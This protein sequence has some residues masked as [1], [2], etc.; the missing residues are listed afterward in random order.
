MV[1]SIQ[2]PDAN[3]FELVEE[4]SSHNDGDL[5]PSSLLSMSA[6]DLPKRVIRLRLFAR[7]LLDHETK[8]QHRLT[9]IARD[10]CPLKE[11]Q[12]V[13]E[14]PITLN[15]REVNEY[16]PV[17]QLHSDTT[18]KS[19][20]IHI[21]PAVRLDYLP[22]ERNGAVSDTDHTAS[23]T[24]TVVLEV[25]EDMPVGSR[26]YQIMATDA[27][28][29]PGATEGTHSVTG[30]ESRRA[31][32]EGIHYSL[33]N[34]VDLKARRFIRVNAA[35]GWITLLQPLD[36]ELGPR[37][38]ELPVLATDSGR[39]SHTGALTVHIRVLDV[40]D[41]APSIEIR[42]LG[43]TAADSFHPGVGM[44]PTLTGPMLHRV[45]TLTVRENA[46]PGTFVAKISTSDPDRGSAGEVSCQLGDP[47]NELAHQRIISGINANPLTQ[48]H[49]DFMLQAGPPNAMAS[50]S[51]A[52]ASLHHSEY[53]SESEYPGRRDA[54]Y[55]LLTRTRLDRET[56]AWYILSLICHDHGD[57]QSSPFYPTDS[58]ISKS[59]RHGKR[60]RRLTSTRLIKVLVLDENDNGPKFARGHWNAQVPEHSS[61]DTN[62]VQLKATDDDAP[63][64]GSRTLYRLADPTEWNMD[65]NTDSEI[66]LIHEYFMMDNNHGWLRTGIRPLDREIRDKYSIPV[67][68]YDAE[69]PNRTTLA[70]VHLQVTDIND[71]VPQLTGNH[72][73]SIDEEESS[74]TSHIPT[75]AI[76]PSDSVDEKTGRLGG[77]P[78]FVGHLEGRDLDS[79]ENGQISFALARQELDK[80]SEGTTQLNWFLRPDGTLF[81]HSS[82]SAPLDRELQA[83]HHVP[84]IVRDHGSP[85]ALSSTATITVLI[86]DRND[87]APRFE[88]PPSDRERAFSTKDEGQHNLPKLPID[89][90]ELAESTSPGTLI[91]TA[92]AH[93][94]D[95]AEN[96]L[97]VY[98][99]EPYQGF[100]QLVHSKPLPI[101]QTSGRENQ[102]T[103]SSKK[104]KSA[105][106]IHPH[107]IINPTTGEIRVNQPLSAQDS[108]LPRRLVIFAQ[109]QGVPA[110]RSYAF[111]YIDLVSATGKKISGNVSDASQMHPSGSSISG[112]SIFHTRFVDS[113]NPQMSV[114][115][116]GILN[117]QQ[118]FHKTNLENSARQKMMLI[119]NTNEAS[120][121]KRADGIRSS[122]SV[123][124]L[125]QVL[126]WNS[127]LITGL[128]IG[129]VVL[130]LICLLLL[131][132]YAVHGTKLLQRQPHSHRGQ[133]GRSNL[134]KPERRNG[135]NGIWMT[136]A[137]GPNGMSPNPGEDILN[138]KVTHLS[139]TVRN[140]W[141]QRS[142]KIDCEL[143]P[144]A[145]AMLDRVARDELNHLSKEPRTARVYLSRSSPRMGTSFCPDNCSISPR[146]D[147]ESSSISRNVPR[148]DP[149]P[150]LVS[151][152][153]SPNDRWYT[154]SKA[155]QRSP[156]AQAYICGSPRLAEHGG[157]TGSLMYEG[158]ASENHDPIS[159]NYS[160]MTN[161]EDESRDTYYTIRPE[162]MCRPLGGS[163]QPSI[164]LR[165]NSAS[166]NNNLQ[167]MISS[168]KLQRVTFSN[169]T[170]RMGLSSPR[171]EHHPSYM[172]QER[173][174]KASSEKTTLSAVTSSSS[175]LE[176]HHPQATISLPPTSS[177]VFN[178]VG[179]HVKQE[180]DHFDCLTEM[181]DSRNTTLLQCS[182]TPKPINDSSFV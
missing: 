167:A 136:C 85:K 104:P 6:L 164:T 39:P 103:E 113:S 11:M 100:W 156:S 144:S 120:L 25:P 60:G 32:T 79:G 69:F 27:D 125:R 64:A 67:V 139:Q 126:S 128:G 166:D 154:H 147:T 174:D 19:G 130:I 83:V 31:M 134:D 95:Q 50:H 122:T 58:T 89:H 5:L 88:R 112:G 61:P 22:L 28:T 80:N 8:T 172:G 55:V 68:A 106:E 9:L 173:D 177:V 129:L 155:N 133:I 105:E 118:S 115:D 176:R 46:P 86:L 101:N 47:V 54:D 99:L 38:F 75:H 56:R 165:S 182:T 59:T 138:G 34:N 13:T 21:H 17:F 181:A 93:D 96:G 162:L 66:N 29:A 40:N 157:Q 62:I 140:V 23:S 169:D 16:A 92:L 63:G 146:D 10:Q 33:A 141:N 90:V 102:T 36:Y 26:I 78:I 150:A 91:Y 137:T 12:R 109:D 152:M 135:N 82:S 161:P 45:Q 42:G 163:N 7:Q 121:S 65:N 107:F 151:F 119:S 179:M 124:S 158:L 143:L 4:L 52:A 97:V 53:H 148:Y 14:L 175:P 15:V 127:E 171:T 132:T 116:K 81:V 48:H 123:G 3:E 20:S 77:R 24:Q 168:T 131:I 84:V 51:V 98:S 30:A 149:L 43:P 37:T 76:S 159:S 57:Q 72:T 41:E 49:T 2:G 117:S 70:W 178:P 18:T 111:L 87:N 153:N 94:P 73:F 114:A 108:S 180:T 142:G 74:L 110:R 71:N 160:N 145:R 170:R 35:D 44:D 1:C